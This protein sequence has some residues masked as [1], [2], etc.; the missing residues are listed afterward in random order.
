METK[1]KL[2]NEKTVRTVWNADEEEWYFSVVDV[3]AV[4]TDSADPKQYI[5]KM[6]TRDQELADKWGTICTPVE[7][8]GVKRRRRPVW[9][10]KRS[11]DI[12]SFPL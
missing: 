8:A 2:F 5:K 1:L 6:R 4:L 12:Q 9:I 3:I 7:S 10:S 11:L